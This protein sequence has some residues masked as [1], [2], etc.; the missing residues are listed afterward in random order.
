[1]YTESTGNLTG[2]SQEEAIS[3]I[4]AE[5]IASA[6]VMYIYSDTPAGIVTD[7]NISFIGSSTAD[8]VEAKL[9]VSL[10]EFT[11]LA[12]SG[13]AEEPY[14][15]QSLGDFNEFCADSSLWA[16]GV[17]TRLTCDIDLLLNET[18]CCAPIAPYVNNA[19]AQVF[20]GYFDGA[21][22]T[23][24]G[25]DIAGSD[26]C[27]LFGKVGYG[28]RVSNLNV[29]GSVSS[30]GIYNGLLAGYTL[31]AEIYNCTAEGSVR[32]YGVAGGL[33]GYSEDT[34]LNRCISRSLVEGG[35]TIGGL[36][37]VC[38]KTSATAA[39]S[40]KNCGAEC[41]V[42]SG[43]FNSSSYCGGLIGLSKVNIKQ[44]YAK[45]IVKA[46]YNTGST[47]GLIGFC[48]EDYQP[49]ISN[50]YF[51]GEL[52]G[53]VFMNNAGGIVGKCEQATITNCIATSFPKSS[54]K[55]RILRLES[56]AIKVT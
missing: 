20:R 56:F 18:Y 43:L 36:A 47:G 44:C 40:V 26:Y 39:G 5:G 9:L 24:S 22:H 8:G 6:N 46:L 38:T 29:K 30:T 31:A 10:G 55:A 50:C 17:Y 49:T 41:T 35:Q 21:G 33:V 12:G 42:Y 53:G 19:F 14:L 3:R 48:M 23:I 16:A 11:G 37:G 45:G 32:S 1:M 54:S 15:I 52:K 7:Y 13:T 34:K 28:G 25:L 2:L 27:A 51:V 4:E